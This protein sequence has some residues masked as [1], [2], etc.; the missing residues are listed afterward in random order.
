MFVSGSRDPSH[1]VVVIGSGASGGMAAWNLTRQGVRVLMLDAGSRFDRRDFWTHVSPPEW[2]DRKLRGEHPPQFYLSRQEQPYFTP[3]EHPFDL[4]RV[5]GVGGKTNVWGRVALRYSDLGFK[6]AERDGWEI[7]WP[8]SYRD[9]A[10]YYDRVDQ[11]IGVCGGSEDLDCLPGSQYHLPPPNPRCGEVLLKKAAA[12][13]GIQIVPIRRAVLTREHN[14]FPACHYCGACGRGCDTA[15]FFNSADHLIPAALNSGRLTLK[16]NAVV[17]RILPDHRGWAHEVQYFNRHTRNEERVSARAIVLGASCIDSTRI[18]LNS[19]SRIYPEGI[20][21]SSGVIGKYLCEQV[22]F[23]V[24]GF[25]P[26]LYGRPATNDDGIGGE[27]I[28][29]PRFNHRGPRRNYL[30]GFGAQFWGIGCQDGASHFAKD[31]P[32]F[33]A[34]FKKEI[35]RRYPAWIAMHPYGEVLPRAENH[36]SVEGT[37]LDS[38]GVPLPRIVYSIGENERKMIEEMYV[39]AEEIMHA[40]KAE[41]IH[42]RRGQVDVAGSAIHEHG[43]CRMGADSKR[44]ALNGFCQMHD[45][46]NLF[47]VDGSAFPSASEKNPTLTILALAWRATDYL[48]AELKKGNLG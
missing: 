47:V 39:C 14:G 20:G 34:S 3:S 6:A 37:P 11:L 24:Y 30:R 15:S 18:L 44:S 35:K 13:A 40:A 7:P 1:D 45:V 23:H 48:A 21:N 2:R 28:Y 19:K 17:A 31:L 43:T 10:P 27:H 42:Y 46:P 25:L 33:G 22:R 5:W 38:Y 36:V 9:L 26:E 4:V 12:K 29:M 16:T 8:L 41:L 32:G